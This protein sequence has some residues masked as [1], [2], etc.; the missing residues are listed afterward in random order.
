MSDERAPSPKGA[1][2]PRPTQKANPSSPSGAP[3]PGVTPA[4]K[5]A[6]GPTPA[7]KSAKLWPVG[8]ALGLGVVVLMLVRNTTIA[9]DGD[10]DAP[11][12]VASVGASFEG[13]ITLVTADRNDLDCAA[14][15]GVGDY[16]CAFSDEHTSRTVD[17][18]NK[19]RPFM[20]TDRRLFL[21]PGLFFEPAIDARYK[22][23]PPNK[24]RSQLKRF[25]A[26]C[27]I[28]VVGMAEDA[29]ARW[30]PDGEWEPSS[31]IPV[32]TVSGCQIAE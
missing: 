15:A 7:Q 29:K 3:A 16:Q 30:A 25:S 1:A 28:K 32:A 2:S 5:S 31:K 12:P 11:A 24:P 6:T 10:S 8:A 21:I 9:T 13:D 27:E 19:L 18:R 17:E 14:K 23:E 26:K 20:T 4:Q 22:T